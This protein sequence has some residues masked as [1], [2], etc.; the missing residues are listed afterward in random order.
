[1]G[2]TDCTLLT[3]APSRLNLTGFQPGLDWPPG[4]KFWSPKPKK[5]EVKAPQPWN[6]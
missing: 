4:A 5:G 2:L 1:M 6:P 3:K